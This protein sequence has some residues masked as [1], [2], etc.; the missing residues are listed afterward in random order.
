MQNENV[1]PV[2]QKLV[3]ISGQQQQLH[4]SQAGDSDS[5]ELG[6]ALESA[7]HQVLE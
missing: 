7:F 4:G 5:E 1:R 3:R 2:V 6:G